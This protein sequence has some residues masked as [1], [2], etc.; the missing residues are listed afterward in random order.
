MSKA[1]SHANKMQIFLKKLAFNLKFVLSLLKSEN[2]NTNVDM[3]QMN[4]LP[5]FGKL[6]LHF[7]PLCGNFSNHSWV[8][9][10]RLQRV[11]HYCSKIF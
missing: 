4:T 6:I 1:S 7:K 5:C 2:F 8:T 10:P 9:S 3:N 11:A